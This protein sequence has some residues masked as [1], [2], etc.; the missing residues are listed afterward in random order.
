[1]RGEG[2]PASSVIGEHMIIHLNYQR[3]QLDS[4]PKN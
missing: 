4:F 2:R 3:L 1:M